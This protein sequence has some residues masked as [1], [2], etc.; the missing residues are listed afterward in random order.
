MIAAVA[1]Q[2]FALVI[3]VELAAREKR[4]KT[5]DQA[6]QEVSTAVAEEKA[7]HNSEGSNSTLVGAELV[8]ADERLSSA[9]ARSET[10]QTRTAATS[11]AVGTTMTVSAEMARKMAFQTFLTMRVLMGAISPDLALALASPPR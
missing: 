8:A 11:V 9:V 10:L 4:D 1:A 7:D 6:T 3:E 5:T 2:T